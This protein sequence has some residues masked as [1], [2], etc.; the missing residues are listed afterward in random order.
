M[1][2]SA[3][4]ENEAVANAGVLGSR[5][6]KSG[7]LGTRR[8]PGSHRPHAGGASLESIQVALNLAMTGHWIKADL[9]IAWGGLV[10]CAI[11]SFLYPIFMGSRLRQHTVLVF[12][13]AKTLLESR[14][15]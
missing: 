13:L 14:A 6:W 2:G 12:T 15:D 3:A 4:C 1:Y 8:G 9:L 7:V 10:V 11:D 5:Y